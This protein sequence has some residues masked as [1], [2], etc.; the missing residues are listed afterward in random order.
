[1][2]LPDSYLEE[3]DEP[4][5]DEKPATNDTPIEVVMLRHLAEDY[6]RI[7]FT[8][9]NLVSGG[10]IPKSLLK[11]PSYPPLVLNT[12]ISD[13]INL[14]WEIMGQPTE[15]QRHRV[16]IVGGVYSNSLVILRVIKD[17]TKL[18]IPKSFIGGILLIYLE[19]CKGHEI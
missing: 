3:W 5:Y 18:R 19:L 11:N 9:Q 1:M 8:T 7:F 4:E 17:C 13:G 2:S 15:K 14:A 12:E 16:E 10:S 6:I